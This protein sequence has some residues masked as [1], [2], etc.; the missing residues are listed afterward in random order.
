MKAFKVG[1]KVKLVSTRYSDTDIN[2]RWG[3]RYGKMSGRIKEFFD[4]GCFV[5]WENGQING[6]TDMNL[7]LIEYISKRH[8]LTKIF[9]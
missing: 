5:I 6:Y 8:P 3:G 2:P 9:V 7:A 4:G 1:D